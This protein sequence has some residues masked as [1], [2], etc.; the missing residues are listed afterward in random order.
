MPF[1]EIEVDAGENS[2]MSLARIFDA[3]ETSY[4][5]TRVFTM[6]RDTGADELCAVTGWSA[7]GECQAYAAQVWDSGDGV[8]LL[9]YGGGEGIRLKPA[10]S[11]GPWNLADPTQWGEPCL[12]LEADAEVG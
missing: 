2:D 9:V 4:E 1:I 5:V 6:R 8:A 12:L 7:D 3:R 11:G 10:D